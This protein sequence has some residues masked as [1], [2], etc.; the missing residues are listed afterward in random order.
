MLIER[1]RTK[2]LKRLETISKAFSL[3]EWLRAMEIAN[4][5]GS[6]TVGQFQGWSIRVKA[7][8]CGKPNCH[9]CPHRF[10]AYGERRVGRKL[11]TK[12]LGVIRRQ[13]R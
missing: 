7:I 13:G 12:Y 10:Y 5:K 4:E 1:K 3:T 6:A 8:R 9:K 11:Q 2:P